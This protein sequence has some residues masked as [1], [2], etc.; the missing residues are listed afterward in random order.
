M[1]VEITATLELDHSHVVEKFVMYML[2]IE[3]DERCKDDIVKPHGLLSQVCYPVPVRRECY[4]RAVTGRR[5]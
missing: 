3:T 2:Q 1:I 4:A 5:S